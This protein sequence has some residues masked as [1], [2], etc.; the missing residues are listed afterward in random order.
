MSKYQRL[1]LSHGANR[2]AEL[3]ESSTVL[4]R[5]ARDWKARPSRLIM[6][7]EQC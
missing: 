2:C 5:G 6:P 4:D 1:R 7:N 3:A